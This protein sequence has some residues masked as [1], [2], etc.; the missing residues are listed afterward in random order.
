MTL[1]DLSIKDYVADKTGGTVPSLSSHIAHVL[2]TRSPLHA[3]MKHPRL[4]PNWRPD[5]D[6]KFDLG[7][8]AHAV[9]L[10]NKRDLIAVVN[11]KDWRTNAAKE[12]RDLTRKDGKIPLLPEDAAAVEAMASV[13]RRAIERSSAIGPRE[14]IAERTL[15]WEHGGTRLRCRPDWVTTDHELVVSYKTSGNVSPEVFS[16]RI[17]DLGYHVQ[18]AWELAGVKAATGKDARYI[19]CAQEVE[20]PYAVAFFDMAPMTL[21]LAER[22]M[23][24]AVE[25][26]AE[27]LAL[28]GEWP[29]YSSRV[30]SVEPSPWTVEQFAER[31]MGGGVEEL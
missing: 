29:A 28:T 4:N 10:E 27:C 25:L 20:P 21:D 13:A 23:A 24:R 12:A 1:A 2:L 26:W 22:S 30:A 17:I 15:S 31:H 16:R 7:T 19:W 9:L 6:E 5:E 18:A 14:F 3:W 11:A 8:A